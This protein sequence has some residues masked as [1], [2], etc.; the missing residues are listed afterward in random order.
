MSS[1][2]NRWGLPHL[3]LGLGLRTE[4]IAEILRDEPPID[5]FE[6]IT[7]NFIV[8]RGFLTWALDAIRERYP[9]VLHGVSLSIGSTDPFDHNFLLQIK[10]LADRVDAPWVSD[11]LCWTGVGGR[12]SHDLLP[13]PYTAE[14]LDWTVARVRHVQDVLERTLVL[15][16]P[17]SY[18][19]F[20][21]AD[22]NEATF[23][24]E[25][26]ERADCGLLLDVNNVYVSSEN[27]DFEA[28]AYLDKIPWD[29]VAQF[30]V[31]GHTRL[32]THI[33]DSH[34][35]PVVEPV[36]DLLAN[37]YQR[38]GGRSTMLE[39]DDEIP[40]LE[41]TWAEAERA[42]RYIEF[43]GIKARQTRNPV[44]FAG[45]LST[46]GANSPEN[47]PKHVSSLMRWVHAV[48]A[49][50]PN[51]DRGAISLHVAANAKMR[52]DQRIDVYTE[53]VRVRFYQS[54]A[55]DF[56][57]IARALGPDK[58]AVEVT[59]YLREHPSRSPW[60]EYM[61]AAFA[62][63]LQDR[64]DHPWLADA[65]R[66]HWAVVQV[67]LAPCFSPAPPD[68]FAAIPAQHQADI[69]LEFAPAVQLVDCAHDV[70]E[71]VDQA[72]SSDDLD[73]RVAE[74]AAVANTILV[75]RP[76]F[77]VDTRR[78]APAEGPILRSLMA[79]LTLQQAVLSYL[80]QH[81]DD[82][83]AVMS[84]IGAWTAAWT[85][86][87]LVTSVSCRDNSVLPDGR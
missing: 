55:E 47:Q 51:A 76:S 70:W 43:P 34:I 58:F 26:A 56:P 67:S 16:N 68:A 66:V 33:L 62:D 69:T 60:M 54:M 86:A 1:N 61:G 5:W 57:S 52:A 31:A 22:M 42:R 87:Q 12:N 41:N 37:A 23:L 81:P 82:A 44:E 11:H 8:H 77:R 29:R 2:T 17:S 24:A 48:I 73:A 49:D 46:D 4:H 19:E 59:N 32:E 36:W 64:T 30:H 18:L 85:A 63:W 78:L 38:C 25:L 39:W 20:T 53:A 72:V 79:G 28:D 65:A 13:V 74:P 35:G 75:A 3:G 27:H 45:S 50:D 84:S 14:M 7:E 10:A 83:E 21:R 40:S 80:E 71:T 15:E 9:I 6:I